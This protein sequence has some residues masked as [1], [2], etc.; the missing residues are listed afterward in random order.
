MAIE[1]FSVFALY[2]FFAV[3]DYSANF[4]DIDMKPFQVV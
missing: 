4:E 2:L 1:I 3:F